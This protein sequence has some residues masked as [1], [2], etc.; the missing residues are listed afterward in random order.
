M[1]EVR[2][3]F[4]DKTYRPLIGYALIF[5][6]SSFFAYW[7]QSIPAFVV[8]AVINIVLLVFYAYRAG[9]FA[10]RVSEL[11]A[12]AV[13]EKLAA[14][15]EEMVSAKNQLEKNLESKTKTLQQS[16]A[17]Y[18]M[19]LENAGEMIELITLEGDFLYV[20]PAWKSALGYDERD[21]QHVSFLGIL[22]PS[23]RVRF[24]QFLDMLKTQDVVRNIAAR[25]ITKANIEIRVEGSLIAL[26]TP[27]GRQVQ[28]IF[29]D[30]TRR[31]TAESKLRES[32]ILFTSVFNKSADAVLIV[33]ASD[34]AIID[35]NDR[36][37]LMLDADDKAQLIGQD[38]YF[39]Q[40][41]V[42]TTEMNHQFDEA[43]T[44]GATINV[45][46]EYRTLSGRDFWGSLAERRIRSGQKELILI[47]ITDITERKKYESSLR[48]AKHEAEAASKA[49]SEFLAMMSHEIRTPMN[50]VIG[51]TSLLME[52]QL[53]PEQY[54]FVETIRASGDSLLTIINDI[55]DFS[56]IESGQM[57]LVIQ[58]FSLAAS[59]EDICSIYADQAAQKD[60]E[61]LY[62]IAPDVPIFIESD[63][64]RL[65]Q[66]LS[67][68]V[69]NAI[70]FTEKGEVYVGVSLPK[71]IES[72]D[73][74]LTL[75]FVVSDTGIGIPEEKMSRLFK[76]FSQVDAYTSRKYGGTGLGTAICERLIRMMNG[77]IW[78]ESEIGVGSKFYFEIPVTV[79]AAERQPP[80]AT[81]EKFRDK[82]V[83]IVDDNQTNRRILT[84]QSER[85][86]MKP[87]AV[88]SAKEAL[89]LMNKGEHFDV[90]LLDMNMP[91]MDGLTLATEIRKLKTK[92]ELP[93]LL[94]SSAMRTEDKNIPSRDRLFS[95]VMQKPVRQS[96]LYGLLGVA[97]SRDEPESI[98]TVKEK[99]KRNLRPLSILLA[100]DHPVNQKLAIAILSQ[101]GYAADIATNGLE[102]IDAI[103]R[104]H[105]D[106]IL[107]DIQM[108]KMDG[109]E[110]TQYIRGYYPPDR[111]P[112]IIAVT[113]HALQ[114]DKERYLSLGID[115]YLSKPISLNDLAN[116]LERWSSVDVPR[117]ST[118]SSIAETA[119]QP[120]LNPDTIQM[121]RDISVGSKPPVIKELYDIFITHAMPQIEELATY[122]EAG[123]LAQ[124][125]SV[126]H[127]LKGSCLNIGAARMGE[128]CRQIEH[129]AMKDTLPPIPERIEH[130]WVVYQETNEAFQDVLAKL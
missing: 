94:L 74:S 30:I 62:D 49:K 93:L 78:V 125:K 95:A 23:D 69:S 82:N 89:A 60:I 14:E 130:L 34:M 52:T 22:A 111:Q 116:V 41:E 109:V 42:F 27:T 51:M 26:Q 29:R 24:E 106:T 36:A 33:D 13:E 35:C 5:S 20:N 71:Q 114:G 85:W 92:T 75:K 90:G 56:K 102:V 63:A 1:P 50:G 127:A 126:A 21:L 128:V 101:L 17:R 8:T 76:P 86:G 64:T 31:V 80:V 105:Y 43:L 97:L 11:K 115:D 4:I 124:V 99:A 73:N 59:V 77:R 61:L 2:K 117:V 32:E 10:T 104:R 123:D 40:K 15:T 118:S 121:L 83:L 25:F 16:Q 100:E 48:Q 107:M 9:R 103:N 98:Q 96:Q 3:P 87:V 91:Q 84:L 81:P 58:P 45:E 44:H 65:R 88:A 112:R 55:L 57:D 120:I 53:T 6:V 46:I 113:A 18:Q 110:T 72:G 70:K 67:N 39:F 47:R 66:I 68:L 7:Y 108:P 122:T 38:R 54:E 19:L 12:Q 119:E 28:G 79:A 129:Y 37:L